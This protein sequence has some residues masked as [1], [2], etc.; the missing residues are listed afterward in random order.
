MY[1]RGFESCVF[2]SGTDRSLRPLEKVS[3]Q[4]FKFRAGQLLLEVLRAVG[5][6]RDERKRYRRLLHRGELYLRLL[7]GFAQT[8][9][10]HLVLQKVDAVALL[11]LS[12]EPLDYPVVP[13]VAAEPVVAGGR[14]DFKDSV[15]DVED[16]NVERSAA[17]VVDHYLVVALLK[18]DAVGEAGRRRLVDD[19]EH[20]EARDGSRVLRRLALGVGEVG[21]AGDDRVADRGAEVFL[22]VLF[23]LLEYHRRN[24]LR[25][26]ALAVD[27]DGLV[28][29]HRTLDRYDRAVG[30]DYRLTFC[31]LTY[32]YLSVL[33]ESYDRRGRALSFGVRDYRYVVSFFHRYAAVSCSEVYSYYFSHN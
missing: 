8:L 10:G 18:V 21:R 12:G 11:E 33:G 1:L 3:R 4:L 2:K 5:V 26:V 14:E 7:R 20:V 24:L 17:E 6:R 32:E 29:A 16:R 19:A 30:V 23:Q 15:A 13:V 22:R 25:R 9:R 27:G 31:K 28:A